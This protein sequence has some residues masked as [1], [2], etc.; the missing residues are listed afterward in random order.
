MKT[1]RIITILL[2]MFSVLNLPAYSEKKLLFL[3]EEFANLENWRPLHFSKIKEHT[4]YSIEIEAENSYLRAESRASASGIVFNKEFDPFQYP[5]LKWR[6]RVSNVYEKGNARLKSG[7]DYPVRVYIIFKYNPDRASFGQRIK[8]GIAKKLYGE[9]PPHSSLNYI[10]ANKKQDR[11]I[12]TNSYAAEAKMILL[13]TGREHVGKWVE[14]EVD[15]IEDYHEAF[16]DDPPVLA[17]I[18][19]MNDSDNTGESSISHIDYI[20]IYR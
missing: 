20:E 11:R 17:S 3:R 8:Y 16:K 9:Y 18:A 2:L 15:L 4:L 6:W 5:R 7:D 1:L 13:Q 10:W 12:I 14:Q 19:I